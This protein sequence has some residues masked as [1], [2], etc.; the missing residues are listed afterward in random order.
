MKICFMQ[1]SQ[2]CGRYISECRQIV[3]NL[4]ECEV[5]IIPSEADVIVQF[6]CVETERCIEE[7]AT[8]LH[9]IGKIKKAN[10]K[11]FVAG[12][13][14]NVLGDEFL[15][16]P[17]VDYVV[18]RKPVAK[19]VLEKLG[20][21]KCENKYYLGDDMPFD[22]SLEISNGCQKK[23]GPCSFCFQGI[24]GIPVRSKP[25]DY[26]LTAVKN[27]TDAGARRVSLL[28]LNTCNYGIDFP[29]HKPLLHELIRKVSNI[30]NA[31][32]IDVYSLTIANMYPE[33]VQ[34]LVTNP[35][36]GL[37]EMG[38][39]CGSNHLLQIMNT[40]ATLEKTEK[41]IQAIVPNKKFKTIVI[42]GHP[43]ETE[44]DFE[45][46]ISLLQKYNL[47]HTQVNPFMCVEGTKASKME[48][49]PTEVVRKR[50]EKILQVLSEMKKQYLNSLL[51][52]RVKAYII[53]AHIQKDSSIKVKMEGVLS[54]II[55]VYTCSEEEY[56]R[57]FGNKEVFDIV[58][59][60]AQEVINYEKTPIIF[61]SEI[62]E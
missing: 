44:Q 28:A 4:E 5:T 21:S 60:V 54:P 13:A 12:C 11:L 6:F 37:V 42:V 47:W 43:G 24:T 53:E 62:E 20:C 61:V 23:C 8:Q 32:V 16:F 14:A 9:Y 3:A 41:L 51:G 46:T 48:Q 39:Q 2:A 58:T 59:C 50:Y 30:N 25:M 27:S 31:K 26:L 40:G 33:L 55:F 38:I 35:K 34:E 45:Q 22:I 19:A 56:K 17:D 36:V 49:I 57:K 29:E 10:A 15:S 1:S 18:Q 7:A 52:T